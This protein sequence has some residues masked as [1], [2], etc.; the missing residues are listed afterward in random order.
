MSTSSHPTP[1]MRNGTG[2]SGSTERALFDGDT[3]S[4]PLE[5]RQAWSGCS[6]GRT[7]MAQRIPR[8]GQPS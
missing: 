2:S 3:G 6:A 8:C 7:L 5:L 4:F 1:E